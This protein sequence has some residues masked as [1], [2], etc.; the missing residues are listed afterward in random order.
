MP[1]GRCRRHGGKTPSGIASPVFKTGRYSKYLPGRLQARYAEAE[2]DGEL[3]ELRGEIAL[4]DARLADLLHRVDTGESGALWAK[5]R[6]LARDYAKAHRRDA[7]DADEKLNDLLDAIRGGTDDAMAWAEVQGTVEQRRKLV[8]SERKRLV[9][10]QQT[11]TVEQ[12]LLLIANI[13]DI[14]RRHVDNPRILAGIS[15]DLARLTGRAPDRRTPPPPQPVLDA[16][17]DGS[18]D[19]G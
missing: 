17:G 9:E 11:I 7:E 3:L 6:A 2:G 1:N 18:P 12:A 8:E 10:L 13:S 4:I 15:A 19:A 16:G 14:I 5:V